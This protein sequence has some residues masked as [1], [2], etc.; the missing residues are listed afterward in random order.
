[1]VE[2]R[3]NN[4]D[5][6]KTGIAGLDQMLFGGVPMYN[7]VLIS[8][9]PGAG[10]TLMAFEVLYNNA[11]MGIPGTFIALEE[12]PSEVLKNAKKAF[13]EFKDIDE[14]LD[15]HIL[16]V[17]GE[18][19]AA[20]LQQGTGENASQEYSFGNVV[21]EIESLISANNSKVVV[22]DSVSLLRLMLGENS[23]SYRRAMVTLMSNLRRLGV[24]ALLTVE[25]ESLG[26]DE[27]RFSGE[28]FMF[29]GVMTMYQQGQEDKRALNIEIV[30]MRGTNHSWALAPYEITP[31]GFKVFTADE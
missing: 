11:K 31:S 10:K 22:I 4:D 13:T 20:R 6:V 9:G 5:R 26:R 3:Q 29:D 8:G 17:D 12:E 14:M 25:M 30:K 2:N 1:M 19:P 23:F 18:D 27:A 28:F 16:Q 15:S 24:T 7:Q 21:S